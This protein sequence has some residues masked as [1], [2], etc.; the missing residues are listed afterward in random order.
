[1]GTRSGN[2]EFEASGFGLEI[3][4]AVERNAAVLVVDDDRGGDVAT[5]VIRCSPP[6]DANAAPAPSRAGES[7][8][9][10]VATITAPAARMASSP[11]LQTRTASALGTARS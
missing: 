4:N 7:W 2:V 9:P 1:M 11:R 8:F 5:R 3:R 6:A 10:D